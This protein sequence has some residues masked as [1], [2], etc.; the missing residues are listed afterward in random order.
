VGR[1]LIGH[2]L[3]EIRERAAIAIEVYLN[4][5]PWRGGVQRRP[6]YSYRRQNV[7]L[8]RC[9]NPFC[10]EWPIAGTLEAGEC[11]TCGE[12]IGER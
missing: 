9:K 4:P 11:L 5:H 12:P 8:E 7:V 2:G 10:R 3:D 1:D 6:E